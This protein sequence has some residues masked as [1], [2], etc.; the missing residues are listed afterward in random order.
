MIENGTRRR[1]RCSAPRIA[2]LR[3]TN[4][5]LAHFTRALGRATRGNAGKRDTL[6]TP[7]GPGA[8]VPP[9]M[10][11]RVLAAAVVAALLVAWLVF[12]RRGGAAKS[13][14]G[15][16]AATAAAGAKAAGT[17]RKASEAEDSNL[18]RAADAEAMPPTV[19]PRTAGRCR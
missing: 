10:D 5:P 17:G 13:A 12:G 9:A 2:A 6:H 14:G 8:P 11:A 1:R 4:H 16:A 3:A 18:V 19:T 15:G 7:Q